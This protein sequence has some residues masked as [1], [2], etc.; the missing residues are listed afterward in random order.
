MHT[1]LGESPLEVVGTVGIGHN[2]NSGTVA[3]QLNAAKDG[4]ISS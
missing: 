1:C 3:Q 4:G 2:G